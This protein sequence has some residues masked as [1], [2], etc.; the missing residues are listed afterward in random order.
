MIFAV[1]NHPQAII[2]G[3]KTETRRRITSL[4]RYH[5]GQTY[6]IQPKRTAK[7]IKEGRILI[8]KKWVELKT[9]DC[10]ISIESAYAEGCHTPEEYEKL[11]EKINPKWTVRVAFKFE[12]IPDLATLKYE[13][14]DISKQGEKTKC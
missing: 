2:D 6:A 7:G 13:V 1:N 4:D 5:E 12:F 9:K 3:L 11:Y 10:P 8:V 14:L